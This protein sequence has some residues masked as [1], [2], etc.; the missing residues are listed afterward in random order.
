M[1]TGARRMYGNVCVTNT[2]C[3]HKSRLGGILYFTSN[4][5]MKNYL[6]LLFFTIFSAGA[7]GQKIIKDLFPKETF[8]PDLG[9][10][11]QSELYRLQYLSAKETLTPK[12]KKELDKLYEKHGEVVTSVWEIIPAECSWYCGG[13]NYAVKA[14]SSLPGTKGFNY[15]AREANDLNY[16]TAWVEGRKDE[17]IGEYLDYYFKNRSPRI[18]SVIISN[19]YIKTDE[20]WSN[21]NRVKKLKM[22]VNGQPFAMLNL[23][24]SRSDQVFETGIVEHNPD[25]TDLVL[26]FE[27][28][29]VYKGSK[30]N[31]TAITEIYF[32]GIDVH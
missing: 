23:E 30:Y 27:I 4:F 20:A 18:T 9:E 19:G 17:G 24:D 8:L 28:V 2:N 26:R 1:E 25:G 10:K 31:D 14:S 12:E 11:R 21:N 6:L 13:G 16:K 29:E 5:V 3:E 22:Y 32:D 7:V 15:A